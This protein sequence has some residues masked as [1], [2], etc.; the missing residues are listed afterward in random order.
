MFSIFMLATIISSFILAASPGGT[1]P[2]AQ[3]TRPPAPRPKVKPKRPARPKCK[4][5]GSFKATAYGPPWNS[6]EGGNLTATGTRLFPGRHVVAVDPR[7]IRLGSLI[8]IWP[9]PLHYRGPFLAADTGG[10]ILGK[11]IDVFV[12]QGN[13]LKDSWGVRPIKAC[14]LGYKRK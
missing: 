12:W 1:P 4:S 9:N 11:H 14:L 7:K 3:P 13:R 2:L 8:R 5:L 10:A 6:L